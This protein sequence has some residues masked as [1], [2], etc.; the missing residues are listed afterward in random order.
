MT[1]APQIVERSLITPN[2]FRSDVASVLGSQRPRV[3]TIQCF[4]PDDP[5]RVETTSWKLF[6]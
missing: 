6:P 2:Q 4:H 1:P 3:A 5:K